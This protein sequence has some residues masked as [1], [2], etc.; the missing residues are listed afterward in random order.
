[1][2]KWLAAKLCQRGVDG[3]EDRRN[4]GSSICMSEAAA[5]AQG[6]LV[7][8]G[9]AELWQRQSAR[10]EAESKCEPHDWRLGV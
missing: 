10:K 5:F 6:D 3:G 8:R 4:I 9:G 7:Y 1:M 2:R